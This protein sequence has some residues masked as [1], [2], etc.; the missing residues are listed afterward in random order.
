MP[1]IINPKAIKKHTRLMIMP[2]AELTSI[3]EKL[4]QAKAKELADETKAAAKKKATAPPDGEK[5]TKAAK[6][7]DSA[8]KK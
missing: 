3:T 8:S 6:T 1:V 5:Q 4:N 2:D 7:T